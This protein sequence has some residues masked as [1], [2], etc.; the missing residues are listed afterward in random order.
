MKRSRLL[1]PGHH[2]G[3]RLDV[4]RTE[5]SALGGGFTAC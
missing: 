4:E 5:C 1:C 3:A 2:N